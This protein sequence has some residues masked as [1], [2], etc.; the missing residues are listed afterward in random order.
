MQTWDYQTLTWAHRDSRDAARDGHASSLI[1]T[2][3]NGDPVHEP[4]DLLTYIERASRNGWHIVGT[5]DNFI[6][7]EYNS[8]AAALRTAPEPIVSSTRNR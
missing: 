5:R 6:L 8:E 3:I 1:I 4:L 2:Q 7:L